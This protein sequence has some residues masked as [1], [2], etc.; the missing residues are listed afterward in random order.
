MATIYLLLKGFRI[1]E[2]RFKVPVGEI[3]IIAVKG[4]R[5]AFVEVKARADVEACEASITPKLRARVR[6]A[7]D[8]WMGGHDCYR[9]YD[10]G[11][12]LIFIRPRQW[13]LYLK[14]GL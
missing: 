12:D 6:R 8:V 7:A 5:L 9:D 4:S 3:D 1:I 10:L 2:R 14:D 11:F 13:P